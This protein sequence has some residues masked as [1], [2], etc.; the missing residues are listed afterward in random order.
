MC[1]TLSTRRLPLGRTNKAFTL[2][3]L[4]V[5]IFIIAILVGLLLPAI[6]MVRDASYRASCA[7][8]LRQLGI[9]YYVYLD[10]HKGKT[11]AFVGDSTWMDKLK[12]LAENNDTIFYCITVQGASSTNAAGSGAGSGG[13]ATG[14]QYPL[15]PYHIHVHRTDGGTYADGTLDIQLAL[16]TPNSRLQKAGN[17]YGTGSGHQVD[18]SPPNF[19]IEIEDLGDNNWTDSVITMMPQPDGSIQMQFYHGTNWVHD[20]VDQDGNVLIA[21]IMTGSSIV[22][23]PKDGPAS[24]T[25]SYGVNAYAEFFGQTSDGG[26]ILLVEYSKLVANVFGAS[27]TDFWP[28]DSAARHKG[29]LNALFKDGSVRA[30]EQFDPDPRVSASYRQ[31]WL[32]EIKQ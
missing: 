19:V 18:V 15:P 5:V 27:S 13:A 32:P 26:K 6:Q 16:D 4:L 20:L 1:V 23:V 10:N 9:A 30:L 2:I 8:N 12:P 22:Y 29:V 21:G 17:V 25:G 24:A 7:S 3:E 14:Q 28:R 31:Y 11:S